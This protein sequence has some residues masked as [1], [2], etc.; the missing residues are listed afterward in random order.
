M[1]LDTAHTIN[2]TSV[3]PSTPTTADGTKNTYVG[4]FIGNIDGIL[5]AS[6]IAEFICPSGLIDINSDGQAFCTDAPGCDDPA[7]AETVAVTG[8]FEFGTDINA[9]ITQGCFNGC[10]AQFVGTAPFSFLKDG[11]INYYQVGD[12]VYNDAVTAQ[13]CTEGEPINNGTIPL[14]TCDSPNILDTNSSGQ[15]ICVNPATNEE[16]N[17]NPE[18]ESTVE[19]TVTTTTNPDG[20]T[21][22]ITTT[23]TTNADGSTSTTVTGETTTVNPPDPVTGA[24]GGT[25]VE[26]TTTD[27][28]SAGNETTTTTTTTT[29]EDGNVTGSDTTTTTNNPQQDPTEENQINEFCVENP[30]ASIC[31]TSTNSGGTSC[32]VPPACSGDAIQC[33]I[34]YKLWQLN[35][36]DEQ[37]NA[38]PSQSEIQSKLESILGTA[39]RTGADLEE[40]PISVENLI[41]TTSVYSSACLP[42][43]VMTIYGQTLTFNFD[44]WCNLLRIAGFLIVLIGGLVSAR[45]V[46]T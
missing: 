5:R 33:A 27:T 22:T 39:N 4:Y 30:T 16:Q 46:I 3:I 8:Y 12:F 42:P 17:S 26:T 28:D 1:S 6:G 35:C 25:T 21:T 10:A 29:D 45:I 38:E 37:E 44:E 18:E 23:V 40:D 20:S 15:S 34:D 19:V 32:S 9:V 24:G 43:H 13:E 7:I 41:D 31:L 11:V 36:T 14:D 2:G